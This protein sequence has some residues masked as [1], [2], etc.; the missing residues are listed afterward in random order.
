MDGSCRGYQVTT[1]S[2]WGGVSL[3]TDIYAAPAAWKA[4]LRC[5]IWHKSKTA[6]V[7]RKPVLID[8]F[9][10]THPQPC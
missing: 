1:L 8:G 7:R 9:H 4:A 5:Y 6:E 10:L 2:A 3:R